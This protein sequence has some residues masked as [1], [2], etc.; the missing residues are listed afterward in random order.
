MS[1]FDMSQFEKLSLPDAMKEFI[2]MA[3]KIGMAEK[4]KV[5]WESEKSFIIE[6]VNC[7]TSQVR[8]VMTKEELTN[9]ICPWAIIIASIVNRITGK[10]LKMEP[11]EFNEIGAKTKLTLVD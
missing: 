4:I 11:S 8:S 9:A 7:S 1:G 5:D 6:S 3:E 10:E 2:K